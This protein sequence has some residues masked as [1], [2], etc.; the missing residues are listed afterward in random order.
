LKSIQHDHLR[1]AFLIKDQ[2]DKRVPQSLADF[3]EIGFDL[4]SKVVKG[5][6]NNM[7]EV[8]LEQIKHF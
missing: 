4:N 5:E 2:L 7:A 1:F 8:A 6:K 3:I